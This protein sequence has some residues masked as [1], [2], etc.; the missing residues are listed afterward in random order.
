MLDSRGLSS[1]TSIQTKYII[2]RENSTDY[3]RLVIL[4]YSPTLTNMGSV[5]NMPRQRRRWLYHDKY[6]QCVRLPTPPRPRSPGGDQF[7]IHYCCF[8]QQNGAVLLCGNSNTKCARTTVRP[9]VTFKS[10][11]LIKYYFQQFREQQ[12]K[13]YT[14]SSPAQNTHSVTNKCNLQIL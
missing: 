10:A 8:V 12:F 3:H 4:N 13:L 7:P 5:A 6:I 14:V 1:E 2:P 9:P 11:Q